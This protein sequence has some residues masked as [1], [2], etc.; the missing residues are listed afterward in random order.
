[1]PKKIQLVVAHITTLSIAMFFL[2]QLFKEGLVFHLAFNQ[3]GGW[4]VWPRLLPDI[5]DAK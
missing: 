5:I 4:R 1:M 2:P 3:R